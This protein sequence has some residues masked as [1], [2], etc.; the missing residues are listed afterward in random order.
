MP[1]LF[2]IFSLLIITSIVM[3][4]LSF[5]PIHSILWLVFVFLLSSGLL[6]SMGIDFIPLMI[7]IIYVGA[8]TILFLFVIMML[9]IIQI[10]EITSITHIIPI[11]IVSSVNV[12]L[13]L[14][15]LFSTDYY[16]G[17]TISY[18][19]WSFDNANQILSIAS[20]LYSEYFYPLVLLSILLIIAMVGAIALTIELGSITRKQ[21]LYL[22]HHRNN[23]WT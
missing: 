22:Q 6:I 19:S 8:I 12:I 15:I 4:I 7:I 10:R 5:N 13:Q 21:A 16:S 18:M 2:I 17:N 23:S 9:D 11:L 14:T 1:Q 20:I 3:V